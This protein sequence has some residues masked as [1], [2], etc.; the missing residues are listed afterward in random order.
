MKL[1]LLQIKRR[2]TYK[3]AKYIIDLLGLIVEEREID[4]KNFPENKFVKYIMDLFDITIPISKANKDFLSNYHNDN[5]IFGYFSG[6][7]KFCALRTQIYIFFPIGDHF[8]G[9]YSLFYNQL[10]DA[11]FE[12]SSISVSEEGKNDEF[13][14]AEKLGADEMQDAW[15]NYENNNLNGDNVLPG[16]KKYILSSR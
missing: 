8:A 6:I 14:N 5:F 10:I 9:E 16:L 3:R 11:Y 12:N 4:K 13:K 7:A 1:L 2:K 15:I